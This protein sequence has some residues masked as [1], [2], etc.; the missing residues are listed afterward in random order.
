M[1]LRENRER[2]ADIIGKP[3]FERAPGG[4]Q[5]LSALL[6]RKQWDDLMTRYYVRRGWAPKNRRPMRPRP[7]VLGM[8]NVADKP[9]L[10][11]AHAE[12][13]LKWRRVFLFWGCIAGLPLPRRRSQTDIRSFTAF[14]R[15]DE[16]NR[17]NLAFLLSAIHSLRVMR[18]KAF[19]CSW[20]CSM[21]RNLNTP[22]GSC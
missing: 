10:P 15:R 12:D 14:K 22:G 3:W 17:D 11:A 8:K 19:F 5:A 2:K 18:I 16:E 21:L 13:F 4:T 9:V 1:V 20:A 7:Q 6:D